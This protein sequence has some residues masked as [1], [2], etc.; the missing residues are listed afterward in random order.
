MALCD[1]RPREFKDTDNEILSLCH[2]R[3]AGKTPGTLKSS[4]Y[5]ILARL[6]TD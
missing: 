4:D 2:T 6:N 3:L 5:K 1:E